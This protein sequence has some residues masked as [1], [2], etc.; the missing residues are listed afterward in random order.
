MPTRDG[1]DLQRFV[2]AQNAVYG[3][4][5][6][7]L[8]EG[9]KRSHWMWFIFPQVEGLGSSP[10]AQRY[11]IGSRQ[12]AEAYLQHPV[13]GERLTECTLLMLR[14]EGRSAHAI[15]GS[16]DDLKFQSS[17]TLF[18]DVSEKGSPFERAL[19]VFYGGKRDRKTV[20]QIGS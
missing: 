19:D 3:T 16:P 20:A 17:M 18:A 15:L 2:D 10:M 14:H 1:F 12:E 11:A 6:R 13:L 8:E 5:V 7:E 9:R 4:V